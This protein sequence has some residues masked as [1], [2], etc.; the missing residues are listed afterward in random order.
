KDSQITAS[1]EFDYRYSAPRGRINTEPEDDLAGAWVPRFNEPGQWI[2][3]DFEEP[4][5]ISGVVTQGREDQPQWVQ[6]FI[7]LISEDGVNF[8]PYTDY[9]GELAKIFPGNTDQNTLVKNPFNRNIIA[10]VIRIQPVTW[11][12]AIAIRFNVLGCAEKTTPLPGTT[13]TGTPG[14]GTPGTVKPTTG[15][16]PSGTPSTEG[17]RPTEGTPGTGTPPTE[18]TTKSS[19]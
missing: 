8:T 19:T 15:Q 5:L 14:T 16:P 9:P 7:V 10:Q 4:T 2:Q 3:V 18:G 12:D 11:E 17:T 1:S 6:S 13:G